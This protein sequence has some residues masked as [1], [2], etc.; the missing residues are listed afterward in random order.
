MYGIH[1][2]FEIPDVSVLGGTVGPESTGYN[3][4][5]GLQEPS[6][7]SLTNNGLPLDSV[8]VTHIAG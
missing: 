6:A 1:E 2:H 8:V 7:A 3:L 4:Q 5:S